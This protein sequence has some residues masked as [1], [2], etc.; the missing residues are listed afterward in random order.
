[1]RRWKTGCRE[2]WRTARIT[3]IPIMAKGFA[4]STMQAE[5]LTERIAVIDCDVHQGNSTAAIF[6]DNPSVFTFSIH[7]KS[8]FPLHK[9]TGD[10][11]IELPDGADN[12]NYL[13][14]LDWGCGGR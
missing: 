11:D 12:S 14:E 13:D 9:E 1:M 10:I 6:A 3:P 4:Y 2:I 8:N 5:Q 7:G